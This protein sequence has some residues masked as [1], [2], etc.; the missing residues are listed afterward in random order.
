MRRR[1]IVD[2]TSCPEK[3]GGMRLW[4]EAI[5]AALSRRPAEEEILVLA[6]LWLKGSFQD[7]EYLRFKFVNTDNF[8]LRFAQ[9]Q[10]VGAFLFYIF[11]ADRY[12]SLNAVYP[13]LVRRR[14]HLIH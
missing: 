2:L 10:L 11:R 1:L 14:L 13:L 3:S 9:Q 8:L 4:A 12:I 6:P 7:G 5:S